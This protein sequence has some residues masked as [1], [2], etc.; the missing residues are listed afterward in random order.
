MRDRSEGMYVSIGSP[1]IESSGE[2]PHEELSEHSGPDGKRETIYPI[3]GY[4]SSLPSLPLV[5]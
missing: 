2:E 3:A 1:W 5:W 4:C